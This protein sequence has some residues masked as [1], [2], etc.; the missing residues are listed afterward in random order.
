MFSC[1]WIIGFLRLICIRLSFSSIFA[2]FGVLPL[3][4]AHQRRSGSSPTSS[5]SSPILTLDCEVASIS[6]SIDI[7][8]WNSG[9][10]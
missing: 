7:P 4:I 2:V 9:W 5:H 1:R 8:M 6:R 3:V 10:P